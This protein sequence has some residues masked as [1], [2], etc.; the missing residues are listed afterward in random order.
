MQIL[1]SWIGQ[2]DL[3]AS[4]GD[5]TAGLGPVAQAVGQR[6]L[7]RVVLLSN[8]PEKD[9]APYVRWLKQRAPCPVDHRAVALSGP[10]NFG[11]IYEAVVAQVRSLLETYGPGTRLTFHLSPGTPAMAAVWIIV[12][13][14]RFAAE[15]IESSKAHGVRTANVPFDI[16]AELI[17][18]LLRRP[19][20]DLER[21]T[22]GLP[23]EAP[24]FA[25]IIHRSDTMRRV[26]A[27]AQKAAPRSVPV[28][29]E[30]ESGTGKELL[31]RAIHNASPR[32]DRPFI[33]VNCG[34]IAADIAESE[35]FGHKK[36]A[37]TDARADRKG[38]FQS[39][40]GGTLFLDEV[41]ELPLPIQ[42]KLLRA[43]Q[44]GQIVRLGES[45]PIAVD[46][47]IISATNRALAQE[48]A[49]ARFREDLF[50][51]LAVAVIRVPPLRDRAG[52]LGL[53]IDHLLAKVNRDSA[54][55][56]AWEHKELS[57]GGRNLLQQ[58]AWPGNVRELLN[59]LTRAAVWS[60]GRTITQDDVR[61]ALLESPG[62]GPAGQSILD[63]PIEQGID[64]QALIADLA[65][66]YLRRAMENTGGNKTKAA[67][68]LGLASYQTLNNWITKYGVKS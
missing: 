60:S 63:L 13:K 32:R 12:A 45:Q 59:T 16:S 41:G 48:V 28:L 2:T 19:D 68:L 56:P 46:V 30:G 38:H 51:R 52:D 15:L 37:F 34:A 42:V 22:A 11:E 31:A 54:A 66:H 7:D 17:P 61:E 57:A 65:R 8:Y 21:L 24:E 39:A 14:T 47:R 6:E 25:E 50:Y 5:G 43:L 64:L 26:I 67:Q 40:D 44:E 1:V 23:A 29:I 4:R 18:E 49:A 58:H 53:L 20:R 10:T 33:A 27:K 9:T 55:E 3:N 62:T 35:L 36:G